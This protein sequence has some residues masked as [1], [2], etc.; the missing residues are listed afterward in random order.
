VS[1]RLRENR[2]RAL[3]AL[4][5]AALGA[6]G[7][8]VPAEP[9]AAEGAGPELGLAVTQGADWGLEPAAAPSRSVDWAV[10]SAV[11]ARSAGGGD[12]HLRVAAVQLSVDSEMLS[13]LEAY[14]SRITRLVERTLPGRPDLVVFPE[15][16]A[17]F[18][19]LVPHHRELAGAKTVAEG[20][21]RVRAAEPLVGNLYDLFALESGW[22]ERAVQELFGGLARRYGVAVLAGSYFAWSTGA[23]G[24]RLTN[25]LVVFGSDGQA[26]YGQDKV[27]LTP[28]EEELLGL[29]PGAISEARP[30]ALRGGRIAV[31]IC[32]DTF[33]SRWE[34]QLA[35]SDLWIDIKANGIAFTQEERERFQRALPAR[36]RSGNVPYGLTVCLN[37][38]LL[39][40]LWEG[41]SSLVGKS[42]PDGVT[43]LRAAPS[44]RHEELL[45]L[46]VPLVPAER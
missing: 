7:A 18:L 33:F 42:G 25:R 26:L 44:P 4:L 20:L 22:V 16:T 31:T 13:S 29:S 34:R 46:S 19:A 40:L 1:G 3:A 17:A 9:A 39:D 28:F 32:R 37:G 43:T 23:E 10:P 30:F 35:G 2:P 36:I 15:Y 24:G 6:A 45:L 5:L 8:V 41:V 12:P 11:P 38:T 14:R 27:Y 21:E